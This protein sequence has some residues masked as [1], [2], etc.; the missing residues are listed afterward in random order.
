MVKDLKAVFVCNNVLEK[1]MNRPLE[2]SW[3]WF[4][5]FCTSPGCEWRVRS[6]VSQ[7]GGARVSAEEKG[8]REV[9]GEPRRRAREPEQDADRGAEVAQGTLL[10]EG[11]AE[12]GLRSRAGGRGDWRA[13]GRSKGGGVVALIFVQFRGR[14]ITS[15]VNS[16][17]RSAMR[18]SAVG[19]VEIRA[20]VAAY[21]SCSAAA[22]F[23]RRRRGVQ[24][25]C[26]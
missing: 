10:P 4:H 14:E 8:V 5:V 3:I 6:R 11:G 1:V 18:Y 2:C 26:F 23:R 7:G 24:P 16:G 22:I 12:L 20:G 15:V 19:R 25:R 21:E 9:S 13:G 17:C